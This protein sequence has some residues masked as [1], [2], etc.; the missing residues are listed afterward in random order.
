MKIK[1]TQVKSVIGVLDNQKKTIK[2]LGIKKNG[3][4]VVQDDSP[5]IRGM[6]NTVKHLV[7]VETVIGE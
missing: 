3:G 1:I 4:S 6:V 7:K 5:V 2:A